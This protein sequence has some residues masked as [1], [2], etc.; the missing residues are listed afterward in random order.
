MCKFCNIIADR[1]KKD[2]LY[3]GNPPG[4]PLR[5]QPFTHR[6]LSEDQ[7]KRIKDELK[8]IGVARG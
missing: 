8:K 4:E 7:L 1:Q 6:N 5:N 3:F 2:I